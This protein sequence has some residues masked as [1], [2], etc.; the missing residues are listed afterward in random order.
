MAYI[1]LPC[2][3]GCRPAG[4]RGT[5]LLTRGPLG[6]A[7][8]RTGLWISVII[9]VA[10]G[11]QAQS[12]GK[13]A[14]V[15]QEAATEGPLPGAS[16]Y[17]EE[18]TNLGTL[19]A[20]DGSYVIL[21]VPPG[22]YTLI[23]SFVGFATIRHEDVQVFSGRTT[24][25]D[26]SLREEVV[27]GEEI[28]VSAERP[29]VIRDRTSTVSYVDQAAIERLPVQELGELVQF[30]P[31]VVTGAGG[32]L[33]FRGGR[34]RETAYIIDGIPV[35][36]V[37]SQSGGN[38]VDVEVQSVQEL[39]VFTGT[40]DAEFG[41]AQSGI[42]SVTTRDPSRTLT[43]QLRLQTGDFY[44]QNEDIFIGG[45]DIDPVATKGAA[46][47]LSGPI[48]GEN[49]GFFFSGRFEDRAG[50][51]KGERRFTAEDGFIIDTYR[52]WYRDVYQPDDTRLISL[53]T[54]RT[55]TGTPILRADGNPWTFSSG[56]GEIVRMEWRRSLT[57]NPKIVFR[58]ASRLHVTYSAL[59][60]RWQGQ[61]YNN[62]R[63]Y[64]P[65]NRS[66]SY[67]SSLAHI[68]SVK[69][70]LGSNKVLAAR[71]S[72]K[73]FSSTSYAFESISDPRIQYISASDDGTGY[74][75]G[76]TDN[77]EGKSAE[78]Q[79]IA[80]GDFTWQINPRNE[81]KTGVQ[82]RHNAYVIEDLDRSWVHRDNPDSLFLAL[83]YPP[84][85]DYPNFADYAEAVRQ[86]LP[87]LV[88]ELARYAVDD[89]FEQ[90]PVEFAAFAQNKLEFD[91]RLVIKL[92]A[93]F[94]YFD[95]RENRLIDPRTP[96]DRIG[97]TDNFEPTP[98]KMYL[99]PRVGISYP[100]SERG[101]F[102]VAYGHFVQMPAYREMFKNP[103]FAT[104]NVG[105]LEGRSVGNPD[106]EPERTI[107]YEMGLQ[108]QLSASIGLDI[109][110]FYKNIRNL[111]GTEI[112]GTLDNV[113][114]TRTVNRDYGLVRGG[115]ISLVT[116][117]EGLLLNATMDLTYS[118]ARG[119]S[120]SPGDVANI[121][122]A[123]RS[124]EVGDLFLERQIIPLNW[125][126]TLTL[127]ASANIGRADNWSVG[128][129]S[130][131]ATGQPY[132]PTFLD[133]N[134]DFPDN[135]FDNALKKPVLFTFDLTAEKRL[136]AGR[137]SYGLRIQ[138][139]NVFNYLNELYVDSVSGRSGQIIR[140]PV[141]QADRDM[142]NDYVG[143]F[144]SQEADSIPNW[145]SSPRKILF[146][147]TVNF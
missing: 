120:S 93:R 62:G 43:G 110:L 75:L 36:N 97:R 112:L 143:L 52:R 35:Q 67:F 137:F 26:G 74:S 121:V 107:K 145:Y 127:N 140:L 138:V 24:F 125:D 144:T 13:I 8:L 82:F 133:P 21:G 117:P 9:C 78:T 11:A 113:Q 53:D 10:W 132:T 128:F 16:V 108:Q 100:I 5:A 68:L 106:L 141:V 18:N 65:D 56:D 33:H 19:T 76:A 70:T 73:T 34:E 114:Y 23:M 123:G 32:G 59:Y 81:F 31:G 130:Q 49:L 17:L 40:F 89:R 72:Y 51:L 96:T 39:Q 101:A 29:I 85:A 1:Q 87:A 91:R 64:A 3:R 41:G 119:S 25:V 50:A 61:G 136:T 103:V 111:L 63:R 42:V 131:L 98:I 69:Q 104:I 142:V 83:T 22:T 115:T 95:V 116:R 46:L 79:V 54:A 90:A 80:S 71:A 77:G 139:E 105:R 147:V 4:D 28:V 129:I 30:Q 66:T 38:S 134:L 48:L 135:E 37:F 27:E 60:N 146:A 92:G 57:L 6:S 109:N 126:Q 99:S 45:T 15:L 47:T 122:I 124:G 55:P 7:T 88:P 2:I 84:A 94:E 14:G 86:L 12:T 58:P 102:R 20:P 44:A 118:D